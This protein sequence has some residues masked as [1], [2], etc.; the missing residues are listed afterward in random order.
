MCFLLFKYP[1]LFCCYIIFVPQWLQVSKN[2]CVLLI[3]SKRFITCAALMSSTPLL[4]L[5]TCILCIRYRAVYFEA[6]PHYNMSYSFALARTTHYCL[7]LRTAVYYSTSYVSCARANFIECYLLYTNFLFLLH[8][9]LQ[10]YLMRCYI[11]NQ[12][13]NFLHSYR[14]W[15]QW[16]LN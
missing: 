8:L 7:L 16:L 13:Y 10:Y 12:L 9:I 11:F 15:L 5:A 6:I 3:F 2:V 14:F 4:C 1:F